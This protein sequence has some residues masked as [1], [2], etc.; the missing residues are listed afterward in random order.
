M[1]PDRDDDA[2]SWAGDDDPTLQPGPGEQKQLRPGWKLVGRPSRVPA[3]RDTD[4][5]PSQMG[6]AMLIALGILAGVYLLYTIG[7]S[8]NIARDTYP[9]P[10]PIDQV[11]YTVGLWLAVAAAPLWFATTLLFTRR[12]V[13]AR[14]VWLII[15]AIVLVPW[16]FVIGGL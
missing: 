8:I 6:S 12:L 3:P 16:P 5:E 10:A 13:R 14:I 11:M 15:G 2:L 1:S 9:A 4:E 7:W